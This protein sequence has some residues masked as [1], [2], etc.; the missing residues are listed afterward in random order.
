[1]SLPEVR[2]YE[3][4]DED[5]FPDWYTDG[6]EEP[7]P[8]ELDEAGQRIE[9]SIS[10][11]QER[12]GDTDLDEVVYGTSDEV[13]GMIVIRESAWDI[14]E[15]VRIVRAAPDS[16]SIPPLVAHEYGH[17]DHERVYETLQTGLS[18]YDAYSQQIAQWVKEEQT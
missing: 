8:E 9:E 15:D 3:P 2:A 14:D 18:V 16:Y 6:I 13:R 4:E 10:F 1:M 11:I 5:R 17:V 12:Y 7:T